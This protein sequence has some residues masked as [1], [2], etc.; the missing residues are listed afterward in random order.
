M[1][2]F[3]ERFVNRTDFTSYE[4]LKQNLEI[5]VPKNFN[6]GFDVVDELARL[7]P[8]KRAM[9]YCDDHGTERIFTYRD[10]MEYSNKTANYFRSLGIGKGD[11]VMLILKRNY[12]FWFSILALHKLGAIVIPATH[13]LTK[14][15]LV[16]RNN[17][18]GIKAIVATAD[19]NVI[20]HVEAC[21]EDSPT[22][23]IKIL[24]RGKRE[25]WEDFSAGVEAASA[26]FPRPQGAE[27]NSSRDIMLIYFTSGTSGNPKMVAHAFDYPLGHII[28]CKFWH[29]AQ[30][31]GLH[32]TVA[33]TGWGK[34]VWGKLYGEWISETTIFVYDMDN[35]VPH[36][37]LEKMQH[38]RITSF[39][40]PPT[41]FR[42]LIKEDLS[43]YDLSSL[44]YCTIAGEALNPE[45]YKQFLDITGVRLME[46]FGQTETV[47]SIANFPW[48]D[49][50]PGSMG[51]PSPLYPV[52]LLDDEGKPVGS[53]T[54]GELC[55]R[56]TEGEN[57]PGLFLCYLHDEEMT[58]NACRGGYYHTGD[59]AWQDEDGYLWFVG[60][61]DD[62]IKSSGYR[63][64][65]FEVESA[66]MEHPA[67]LET[68][69]TAVPD[70]VR[71]QVVKATIVLAKGY[72]ASEELKKEL[73]D[74]VKRTTAPY[75]YPRVV[76][77]VEELPK[78]I[79]GKIRRVE[80]RSKDAEGKEN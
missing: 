31:D 2:L 66:L 76:E 35:F 68:A 37:L 20:E 70:E 19:P 56:L 36:L 27:A 41:I 52:E 44:Q 32:L 7:Y 43:G 62:V 30:P 72:T 49:P 6:F 53:G 24:A 63:I 29:N 38:Y 59:M 5:N 46:G 64:G 16:Y 25:G 26:D 67:V 14:K 50:K 10:M 47:C 71:G 55:I 28:T 73:Q 40:A 45:V 60:R 1:S 13:L 9:I 61:A 48:M 77:F 74:H 17:A 54:E 15:D 57:I 58:A 4:D 34:A 75:K 78:T 23:K 11:Y 12:E 3:V 42:F 8:D 39:C 21:E 18:A 51:K 79:S 65:P 33:D 69:I 80:I 22:L